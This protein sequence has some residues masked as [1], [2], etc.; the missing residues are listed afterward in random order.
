[1]AITKFNTRVQLK[2]DTWA[3]WNST[4]GQAFIPLKGE[5]CICEV[6]ANTAATGEVLS[7]KAYLIKV[8]DGTTT[9][10]SLPWLSAPAADVHA[11]AKKS[12]EDFKTWLTSSTGPALATSSQVTALTNTIN[13]LDFSDPTASGTATAVITNI[14]QTNGKISATK[15]NLPNVSD[16]T[17]SGTSITFIDTIKQENGAI[18]PTKKTVRSA[19][20]TAAGVVTLGASGGAATYA[21]AEEAASIA[22]AA[23]TAAENAQ[24]TAD[25]GVANAKTANDAIA[26]MDFSSPSA[27][28][29]TTS[30]I[31]TVSQTN[32]KITAT[33]KTIPSASTSTAGITKLGV[34]GG[35]ATYDKVEIL[36]SQITNIQSKISNAM[37]FLGITTTSLS[38]GATTATITI[39]DGETTTNVTLTS[40][41]AGAVVLTAEPSSSGIQYEYVWTGSVWGQLG[42]EGSFA[43]KG[44]I[45]NS[46]ISS[47]AAIAATKIASSLNGTNLNTDITGL[48]TRL[49]NAESNITSL[50]TATNTT[51]PNAIQTA[52]D[53]LGASLVGT[54]STSKTI[55]K[56][57][58][59]SAT[60]QATVTYSNIVSGSTSAKGLV[61]LSDAVDSTSTSLAATANAVKKAY[62]LATTANSVASSAQ[63]TANTGVAN[64][65]TAND[66]IAAMD[67]TDP[68][69]SGTSTSFIATVSQTNGKVSATKASLPTSSTSVAG[70]VKLSSS[71]SS[72]SEALAATPKAVKAAYDLASTA[73]STATANT[74][75]LKLTWQTSAITTVNSTNTPGS[76]AGTAK[77]A[78]STT[79]IS[80]LSIAEQEIAYIIFDCGSATENI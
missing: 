22:G 64:A 41:D 3:N 62:D 5:V 36:A 10:D 42:Q 38:D 35:A 20:T 75:K 34:T 50:Q 25:T 55:S 27:S 13:E 72:T 8:G 21:R 71:T 15:K 12:E 52:V 49:D 33:K 39:K 7:E 17:A 80:P 26:A 78:N 43:V 51:L 45:T 14:S 30:F 70:I 37:H 9:F 66:A 18:V 65:K 28:G 2:F 44:S 31:D 29:N 67:L 59:D 57:T 6:P 63:S 68:T 77:A 46:D 19:T 74:N 54:G 4:I 76:A 24:S 11:W 32:G 73:S 60:N 40:A 61:Q 48:D 16:P 58:Y 23:K 56:I 69:A 47:S 79:G 1:M 53:T